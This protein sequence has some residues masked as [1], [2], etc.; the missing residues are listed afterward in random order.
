VSLNMNYASDVLA[1]VTDVLWNIKKRGGL[2]NSMFL[3]A[4]QQRMQGQRAEDSINIALLSMGKKS[5]FEG[6]ATEAQM[7]VLVER[8]KRNNGLLLHEIAVLR[9]QKG[10]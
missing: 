10:K 1:N 4:E 8:T 9:A 7:S 5:A 3:L 2:V 6:Q